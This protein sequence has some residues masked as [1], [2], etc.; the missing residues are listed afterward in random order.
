MTALG[1]VDRRR[2]GIPRPTRGRQLRQLAEALLSAYPSRS[3]LEQVLFFDLELQLS[4]L[5]GN[6][7]MREVIFAVITAGEAQGWLP[8]FIDGVLADRGRNPLIR[9][10]AVDTGWA[11]AAGAAAQTPAEPRTFTVEELDQPA[12]A[13]SLERTIRR[14]APELDPAAWR[15]RLA[16]AEALVCRIDVETSTGARPLGTGFLIG[17]DL[18]LTAYHVVEDVHSGRTL[19]GSLRLRFGYRPASTGV[20][21]ELEPDWLVAWSPPSAV[22]DDASPGDQLPGEH[23]LDF[24]VLRVAGAPGKQPAASG[25]PRGWV[26]AVRLDAIAPYDELVLLH[27]PNAAALTLAFGALLDVNGNGTRLRHTVNTAPGSSGSPCFDISM[28]L[29]AMHH[30]SDPDTSK[31]HLPTHNRAVPI[32]AIRRALPPGVAF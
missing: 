31:L 21:F 8:Q 3:D 20:V 10:W 24:A 17:P 6:V 13:S 16:A 28:A 5:V 9:Q 2:C 19:P 15:S 7:G 1:P 11:P 26:E 27:H 22:D 4:S 14:H 29:V 25:A 12:G 18:C 30:G 32:A 23:E